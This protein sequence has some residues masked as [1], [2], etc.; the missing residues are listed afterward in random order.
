MT[1]AG[2]PRASSRLSRKPGAGKVP[3]IG[4]AAEE[5][6]HSGL[7]GTIERGPCREVEAIEGIEIIDVEKVAKRTAGV[8]D[9]L[10]LDEG[11]AVRRAHVAGRHQANEQCLVA[12]GI[13]NAATTRQ[14]TQITVGQ[15]IEP[16]GR[17]EQEVGG[18]AL[19]DDQRQGFLEY[20]CPRNRIGARIGQQAVGRV[21][22]AAIPG[23]QPVGQ[24]VD[25]P[26]TGETCQRHRVEVVEDDAPPRRHGVRT[27]LIGAQRGGD[28]LGQLVAGIARAA[29]G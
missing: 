19:R 3:R 12:Q 5:G 26:V 18:T 28:H 17:F 29:A 6:R 4:K 10:A 15:A 11:G 8:V 20:P 24:S 14:E 22:I 25:L 27:I 7:G 9:G 21:E 2:S 23:P 16:I 13:G 1:P